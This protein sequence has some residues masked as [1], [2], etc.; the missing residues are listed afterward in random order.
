MEN[1]REIEE[2]INR[3]MAQR[4]PLDPKAIYAQLA[5][6]YGPDVLYLENGSAEEYGGP[7]EILHGK[8]SAG[9]FQLYDNGLDIV[10][11][12]DKADGTYTHWH[13]AD[14][15]EAAADVLAFMQGKCRQ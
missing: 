8:S 11:D 12:V 3:Y 15:G 1:A 9:R 4:E 14:C 10:F 6:M 7:V 13:P 5:D 2:R